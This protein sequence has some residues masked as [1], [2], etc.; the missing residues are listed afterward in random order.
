MKYEVYIELNKVSLKL[1]KEVLHATD[2]LSLHKAITDRYS[3]FYKATA[4]DANN[5][6]FKYGTHGY[7][8]EEL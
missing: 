3:K 1:C 4:Y 2:H 7:K 6:V 5:N 8:Y